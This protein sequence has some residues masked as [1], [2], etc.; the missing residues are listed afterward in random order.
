MARIPRAE[1]RERRDPPRL[2]PR[3]T[4]LLKSKVAIVTGAGRGTGAVI[5][6]RFA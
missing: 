4:M 6:R 5:A 2:K 1:D 3:Y